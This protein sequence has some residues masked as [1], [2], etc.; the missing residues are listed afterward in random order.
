MAKAK[1]KAS[2][3]Q[4]VVIVAQQ[5]LPDDGG[6]L[7]GEPVAAGVVAFVDGNTINAHVFAPKGPMMT[8]FTGLLHV[9]DREALP[10]EDA[11]RNSPAWKHPD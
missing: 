9:D 8:F 2:I 6:P 4:M 11:N 3:G 7:Q 10:P 1:G 5:P